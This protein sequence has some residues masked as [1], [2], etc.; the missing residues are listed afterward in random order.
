MRIQATGGVETCRT[1]PR[2]TRMLLLLRHGKSD[3]S[4]NVDDRE[5][6]LAKRGRKAA[7]AIG[8]FLTEAGEAPDAVVASPAR[9]GSP[10][11]STRGGSRGVALHGPHERPPPMAPM[12]NQALVTPFAVGIGCDRAADGRRSRTH[13]LGDL[14]ACALLEVDVS[15]LPTRGRGRD[16]SRRRGLGGCRT[17]LRPPAPTSFRRARSP[18]PDVEAPAPHAE[19]GR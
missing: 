11:R 7:Q 16:E 8:R 9:R 5:R 1:R 19:R 10:D 17:G 4:S 14:S 13:L 15:G 18:L 3:W 2:S 12:Q 6:P